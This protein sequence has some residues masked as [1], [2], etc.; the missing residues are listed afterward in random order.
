MSRLRLPLNAWR[1]VVFVT[2]F[3][4]MLC[5]YDVYTMAYLH[6]YI[7]HFLTSCCLRFWIHIPRTVFA[8]KVAGL[9]QRDAVFLFISKII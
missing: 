2:L 9:T 6:F 4:P 3:Y 7:F 8:F 1:P 5:L